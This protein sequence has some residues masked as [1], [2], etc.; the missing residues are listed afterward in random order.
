MTANPRSRR[1]IVLLLVAIG[2][3]LVATLPQ[4]ATD[5]EATDTDGTFEPSDAPEAA[6]DDKAPA[7]VGDGSARKRTIEG[8]DPVVEAK[9]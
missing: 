7:K 2:A 3:I 5:D 4:G 1:W 6:S 8:C 9:K